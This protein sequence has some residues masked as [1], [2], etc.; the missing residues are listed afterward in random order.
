MFR[1]LLLIQLS[2]MAAGSSLPAFSAQ[3]VSETREPV[4]GQPY[5]VVHGWPRLPADFVP[6]PVSLHWIVTRNPGPL[7]IRPFASP[8]EHTD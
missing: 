2:L 5:S 7:A 4:M 1:K 6:A 3:P 8:R